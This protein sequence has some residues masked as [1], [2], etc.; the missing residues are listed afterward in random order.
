MARIV[1]HT[2]EFMSKG[3]TLYRVDIWRKGDEQP[4][5]SQPAELRFEAVEPLVIDWGE[6][7]KETPICGSTATLS[8]ESPGDRTYIGLYTVKPGA[9]GLDVY[10]EGALYWCGTLDPESY[11][12]PYERADL[13]PVSLTFSD[14]GMLDRVAFTPTLPVLSLRKILEQGMRLVGL[15][16]LSLDVTRIALRTKE[17][18][19]VAEELCAKAANFVDEE[20]K[21]MTMRE[22]LEAML[23][24]C[25]LK[26]MQR[27]GRLWLYDLQG[28]Y[29][30][31]PTRW[32]EWSSDKQ[33]LAVDKVAN[34][35]TLNFSPYA[36]TKIL[37][38]SDLKF[39]KRVN[40]AD[41]LKGS[42]GAAGR[43][44]VFTDKKAAERAL[45]PTAEEWEK[46]KARQ[47][48]A[49]F[50]MVRGDYGAFRI[51]PLRGGTEAVGV[52]SSYMN[53]DESGMQRFEVNDSGMT[54]MAHRSSR[55]YLPPLKTLA[56]LSPAER[57]EVEAREKAELDALWKSIEEEARVWTATGIAPKR[58]YI[59]PV[60]VPRLRIK[61]E[62]LM[63][64]RYN[65]FAEAPKPDATDEDGNDGGT[66][67]W[68]KRVAAWCFTPMKV[69]LYDSATARTP[70]KTYSNEVAASFETENPFVLE[71]SDGWKEGEDGL[72]W[73][74]YY[75]DSGSIA[76][77]SALLKGWATNKPCIG[78]PDRSTTNLDEF[79]RRIG[80][81]GIWITLSPD[82]DSDEGRA[83]YKWLQRL[84]GEFI[85]Y[86]QEGGWL[87]IS[88][89]GGML[90]HD[91]QGEG[92]N[93]D[94]L[95]QGE[96]NFKN[97]ARLRA[98]G[99]ADKLRW[100]LF[101]APEVEVV[102]NWGDF[103]TVT[104]DDVETRAT[105]HP[106]AREELKFSLK[107]GTL[108]NN[109]TEGEAVACGVY[110][111]RMGMPLRQLKRAERVDS[112]ER[113]FINSLYSQYATRCA[114]ISGEA[115]IDPE[116]L[117][118]YR[119]HAQGNSALFIA[120]ATRQDLMEDCG[121]VTLVRLIN[122]HYRPTF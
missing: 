121:D 13:Y 22:A 103:G 118:R 117:A 38:A 111:N 52:M 23:Q 104:V 6:T 100:L 64:V 43:W 92:K 10:R 28:L 120:T 35:V 27:S 15:E 47:K 5:I 81:W 119:E 66:Y 61:M 19:S 115:A 122:E 57:A 114:R 76:E 58:D 62:C 105:L 49:E 3:G 109:D 77:D 29:A 50:M 53:P 107:C 89:G 110:V 40:V 83:K 67:N 30:L 11:E 46:D 116:G 1:T 55:V 79:G 96:D 18:K 31:A 8:I 42:D 26:L 59:P 73:L 16:A 84:S 33:R 56:A 7:S 48:E 63:D 90:I 72:L 78:R 41:A 37:D 60:S 24:P 32:T 74:A 95:K 91:Y 106:D 21:P 34:A 45:A 36:Q 99:V 68:M 102:R 94:A 69:A 98:L 93:G 87:E 2:G 113:L 12:E 39:T 85:E 14:F 108:P 101:K 82:Y 97:M 4:S 44:V 65:P 80:I 51:V 9:V 17:G 71:P 75:P 112:P 25:G 20:G 88:Y 86:P 70:V 54:A